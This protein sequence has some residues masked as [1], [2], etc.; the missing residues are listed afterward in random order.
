MKEKTS[1]A[2][3]SQFGCRSITTSENQS[4]MVYSP[5]R[6]SK[7]KW[8]RRLEKKGG[9][10]GTKREKGKIGMKE[11]GKKREESHKVTRFGE[12]TEEH[13]RVNYNVQ[14]EREGCT[15]RNKW[16]IRSREE[17]R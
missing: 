11:R 6:Y 12:K 15:L 3:V 1:Y 2:S 4:F 17:G 8:R 13:N 7:S 9:D 14:E 10:Q 16:T 5:V